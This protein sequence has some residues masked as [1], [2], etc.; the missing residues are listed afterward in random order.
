M[1]E[2]D[3]SQKKICSDDSPTDKELL[4]WLEGVCTEENKLGQGGFGAVFRAGGESGGGLGPV[5]IKRQY[6]K[7]TIPFETEIKVLASSQHPNILRLH[8]SYSTKDLT[9]KYR[10]YSM[11]NSL[12][13]FL[14]YENSIG[15]LFIFSQ[16]RRK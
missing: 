10:L 1:M 11:Y 3:S 16:A 5:A 9:D 7:D 14:I 15:L 4:E 2:K 13:I 8:G 12:L 6:L